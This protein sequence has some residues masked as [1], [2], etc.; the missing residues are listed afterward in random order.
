MRK[1]I[2]VLVVFVG[3][4][5]E[6][7]NSSEYVI[8]VDRVDAPA[9]IGPSDTLKARIFGRV[10]VSD[11]YS[12]RRVELVRSNS[13]GRLD[14]TAIGYHSDPAGFHPCGAIIVS[15]DEPIMAVPPYATPP[16]AARTFTIAVHQPGGEVTLVLVEVQE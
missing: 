16:S 1:L 2:I 3:V 4:A 14:V 8:R 15:L 12:L 6:E 9:Q 13:L 5:C 10:G 11:C 7:D